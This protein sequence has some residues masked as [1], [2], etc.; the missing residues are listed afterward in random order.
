MLRYSI[1]RKLV[2]IGMGNENVD[3]G[4]LHFHTDL[5]EIP[6]G[7]QGVPWTPQDYFEGSKE[8]TGTYVVSPTTPDVPWERSG[9]PV[10]ATLGYGPVKGRSLRT[11]VARQKLP[12]RSAGQPWTAVYATQYASG[13]RVQKILHEIFGHYADDVPLNIPTTFRWHSDDFPMT[14][15]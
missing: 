9:D 15:W 14:L 2:F 12:W 10:D 8:F 11:W 13:P 5:N 7:P 1:R 3:C 4:T 6:P